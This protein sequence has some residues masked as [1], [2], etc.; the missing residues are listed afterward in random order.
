M[1]QFLTTVKRITILRDVWQLLLVWLR[2]SENHRKAHY[3]KSSNI[4]IKKNNRDISA[5]YP[6]DLWINGFLNFADLILI[7]K[8]QIPNS[9]YTYSARP[10]TD[11][12]VIFLFP[13]AI[14]IIGKYMCGC[15]NK[16]FTQLNNYCITKINYSVQVPA[17]CASTK[18]RNPQTQN[19]AISEVHHKAAENI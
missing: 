3:T 13:F 9:R 15:N 12:C 2:K 1:K 4:K 8:N 14:W 7:M 18:T 5:W 11:Q 19:F 10:N 6:G 16:T 17:H